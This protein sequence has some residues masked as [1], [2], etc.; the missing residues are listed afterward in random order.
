MSA[1]TQDDAFFIKGLGFEPKAI[2]SPLEDSTRMYSGEKMVIIP[3]LISVNLNRD[4]VIQR[5][6]KPKEGAQFGRVVIVPS[7]KHSDDYAVLG[8]TVAKRE[9]INEVIDSLKNGEYINTVVFVNRY[10]GIDLPDQSC[11][12]LVLDS[13]PFF[14]SLCDIIKSSLWNGV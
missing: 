2:S 12:V 5:L 14:I 3:S 8:S 6:A 7:Y 10:D 9:S 1:T 4:T 11:R 13:M